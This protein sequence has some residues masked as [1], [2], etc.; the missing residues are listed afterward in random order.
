MARRRRSDIFVPDEIAV[1]HVMNRVAH[2]S[3]LFGRD[4][5]T[6]VDYFYRK[7]WMEERLALQVACFAIDLLGYSF[8]S[9][10]FHQVLRSRPDIVA[11]W[12]D[13]EVARR[14]LILCP[15]AR[16]EKGI[17]L[18]P[19]EEDIARLCRQ[20]KRIK[21]LRKRLSDIS[22]WMRLYN[23]MIAQWINREDKTEGRFWQGRFKAVRLL[24]EASILAC[25][26]YVDLNPIRA[27]LTDR[28]EGCE[29]TSIL[30]RILSMTDG[31]SLP[32]QETPADGP[33]APDGGGSSES[34]EPV[35]ADAACDVSLPKATSRGFSIPMIQCLSPLE[36]LQTGEMLGPCP[37]KSGHRCSN[38]GVLSV[39]L[40]EYLTLL[41]WA[42]R[43]IRE[44]S[45]GSTPEHFAPLFE[46]LQISSDVWLK[47]VRNFR[48]YF[49]GVA[50]HPEKVDSFD[51]G[52]SQKR[53]QLSHSGKELFGA[54][55]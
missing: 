55:A 52:S 12:S 26:A 20:K 38:K 35:V 45:S 48:R 4:S 27:G 6:G 24:D 16:D 14:W 50:G 33:P 18:E 51:A 25:M 23:Q 2:G 1:V 41:D 5:D 47:L 13:E 29:F 54:Q 53:F 28:L 32:Q 46:R 11:T 15:V 10:H 44:G 37:C 22:W 40:P 39:S 7:R 49:T 8:L 42:A 30:H 17:A 34:S 9:N 19:T 31:G 3:Y 36:L 21:E 43:Q